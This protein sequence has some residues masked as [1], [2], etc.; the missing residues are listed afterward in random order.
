LSRLDGL[1]ALHAA[2]IRSAPAPITAASKQQTA[3][4]TYTVLV[5]ELPDLGAVDFVAAS[6]DFYCPQ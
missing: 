6:V 2:R 5:D 4:S 3:S 1:L